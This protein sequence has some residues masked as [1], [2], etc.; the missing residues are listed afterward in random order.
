MYFLFQINISRLNELYDLVNS[1][2]FMLDYWWFYRNWGI[3]AVGC[4]ISFFVASLTLFVMLSGTVILQ[5]GDIIPVIAFP[6]LGVSG[7]ILLIVIIPLTRSLVS[8]A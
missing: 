4:M 1:S 5:S 7:F 8:R 6:A 2:A 3:F